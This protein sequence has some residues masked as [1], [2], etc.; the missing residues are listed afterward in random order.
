MRE[1][2]LRQLEER[3][4]AGRRWQDGDY[5]FTTP[6]GQS[7]DAANFTHR[8]HAALKA[9][10]LPHQRFH[11]LRHACATLRLEQGEELA[12]VSRILGHASITTTANVWPSDRLDARPS[13]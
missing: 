13:G 8:F 2:R 6:T 11:D 1:H 7:L 4:A 9:A 5:V 3:L 12:V 10:G